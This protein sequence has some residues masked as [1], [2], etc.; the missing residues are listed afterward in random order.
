M[1]TAVLP[2]YWLARMLAAPRRVALFTAAA[3]AAVPAL[4]YT[5]S[6]M[7]ETLAYPYAVLC[8]A[9]IVRA[10]SSRSTGWVVGAVVA[11]IL[12]PVVRREL[13]VIPVAFAAAALAFVAVRVAWTLVAEVGIRDSRHR[14][15]ARARAGWALKYVSTTWS[16]A[17]GNPRAMISYARSGVASVVIGVA[18]LPAIAGLAALVPPRSERRTS[19]RNAL[20][21]LFVAAA[22][23]FLAVHGG[24]G[25]LL[26]TCAGEPHRGAEP[27][28]P[29]PALPGGDGR[30]A[31]PHGGGD[32]RPGGRNRDRALAP[33]HRPAPVQRAAGLGRAEPRGARRASAGAIRP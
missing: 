18:I 25:R 6:L 22:A 5:S 21:C 29:R 4:S 15:G 24:Q 19:E 31:V 33:R 10:L 7:T 1:T 13:A 16:A 28:L 27:H 23:G 17:I 32:A 9:L 11:A 2:A 12:A 14:R 8:F 20:A 26:R 30:M 3:T